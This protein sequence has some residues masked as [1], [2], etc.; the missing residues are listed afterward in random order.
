MLLMYFAGSGVVAIIVLI[1]YFLV[2]CTQMRHF[3]FGF[4]LALSRW[5]FIATVLGGDVVGGYVIFLTF[6]CHK[7]VG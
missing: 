2:C 7:I 4:A 6:L 1:P 3:A 5:S